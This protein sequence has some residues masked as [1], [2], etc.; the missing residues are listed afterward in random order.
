MQCQVYNMIGDILTKLRA[1]K[2]KEIVHPKLNAEILTLGPSKMSLILHGN[3]F[4]GM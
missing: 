1:K 2:F 4:G 3:R